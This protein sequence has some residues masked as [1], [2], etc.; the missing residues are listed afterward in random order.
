[1]TSD[2]KPLAGHRRSEKKEKKKKGKASSGK[3]CSHQHSRLRG[4]GLNEF[5]STSFSSRS[6]KRGK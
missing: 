5:P 2:G 4:E 1:V 6:E 3:N